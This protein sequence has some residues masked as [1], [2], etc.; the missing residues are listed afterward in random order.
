MGSLRSFS[1]SELGRF[2]NA[3]LACKHLIESQA[4]ELTLSAFIVLNLLMMVIE[5]DTT[6]ADEKPPVWM[7]VI[8]ISLLLCFTIES[9]VRVYVYRHRFFHDHMCILDALVVG[10]DIAS[11]LA[12]PSRFKFVLVSVPW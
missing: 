7:K 5:I 8:N 2:S 10:I 3:R 9:L 1:K 4:F 6:Q 11:K 12:K